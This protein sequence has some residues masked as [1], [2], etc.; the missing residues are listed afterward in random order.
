[1]AGRILPETHS[2]TERWVEADSYFESILISVD[3]MHI[4]CFPGPG[5]ELHRITHKVK[6]YN[7]PLFV[8]V[9]LVTIT[10]CDHCKREAPS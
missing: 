9:Q 6:I 2:G 4:T 5:K 8:Q 7:I 1:M 3:S 10:F